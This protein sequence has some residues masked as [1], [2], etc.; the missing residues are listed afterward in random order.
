M[1]LRDWAKRRERLDDLSVL[2]PEIIKAIDTKECL[3]EV[4]AALLRRLAAEENH[5]KGLVDTFKSSNIDFHTRVQKVEET[6][7]ALQF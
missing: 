4:Q 3:L 2:N 1:R 7:K 6:I 5:V